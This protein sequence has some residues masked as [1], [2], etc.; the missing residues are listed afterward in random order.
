MNLTIRHFPAS[1]ADIQPD[2]GKMHN[3]LFTGLYEEEIEV[4]SKTRRFYTYLA[5]DL[6]ASRPVLVTALPSDA[7]PVQFLR[8]SG[9]TELAAEEKLYVILAVPDNGGWDT[10]GR[11]ADYLNAVYKKILG[12]EHYIL[13][14]ECI[15]LIGVGDGSTPVHEAAAKMPENWSGV[16]STGTICEEIT[17][18]LHTQA[19]AD[20]PVQMPVY[21]ALPVENRASDRLL[22]YWQAQNRTTSET[23]SGEGADLI[24]RPSPLNRQFS[25]NDVQVSEIRLTYETSEYSD[26][27]RTI[28][29][30]WQ[31][32]KKNRRHRGIARKHMRPYTDW[33]EYGAEEYSTEIDGYTRTWL[34]YVPESVRNGN[35][36]VPLVVVMH[37]RTQSS[38]IIFDLTSM[39]WAA[40]QFGFIA[41]FPRAGI[42]RMSENSVPNVPLWQGNCAGKNFDDVKFIR[43]V[44]S[45]EERRR[46]IDHSRIYACGFSSGGCMSYDLGIQASDLFAAICCFSGFGV[47]FHNGIREDDTRTPVRPIGTKMIVGAEDNAFA[48]TQAD[49]P[50]GLQ[51]G[52]SKALTRWAEAFSS[53]E[54]SE[55][56]VGGKRYKVHMN[57][58]GIPMVTVCT[59]DDMPHAVYPSESFEAYE[60]FY[61]FSRIEGELYYMGR[62]V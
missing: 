24:F 11:D 7:D 53:T 14:Q 58:R 57:Q 62:K 17:D 35:T 8:E 60:F 28:R 15:Y 42:Y 39:A 12:R 56:S 29:R 5:P 36:E 31:F 6:T 21:M 44:V 49:N 22:A 55:Y 51:D 1:S 25:I 40:E 26:L 34:E 48:D 46:K 38:E 13:V 61:Q 27:Q 54:Y 45:E 52:V 43:T 23:Y 50:Y 33:R 20:G 10:A 37:G 47:R 16:A 30:F 59:V 19:F 4:N 32:L 2:P 18:F 3:C 9:L 41:V